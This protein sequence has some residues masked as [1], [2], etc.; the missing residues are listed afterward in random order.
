MI[1]QVRVLLSWL[2]GAEAFFFN[3]KLSPQ[4][5]AIFLLESCYLIMGKGKCNKKIVSIISF[6]LSMKQNVTKAA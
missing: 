3:F 2:G 1:S 5:F 6:T 4:F